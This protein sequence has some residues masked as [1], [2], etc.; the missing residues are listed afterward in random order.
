MI[1]LQSKAARL[2]VDTGSASVTSMPRNVR[3]LSE[4]PGKRSLG[5]AAGTRAPGALSIRPFEGSRWRLRRLR[6]AMGFE[7]TFAA[8]DEPLRHLEKASY[9]ESHRS[10]RARG[11]LLGR[12]SRVR[13]LSEVAFR[14][15]GTRPMGVPAR[16]QRCREATRSMWCCSEEVLL[17]A[18]H[19]LD[20]ASYPA[21]KYSAWLHD[22]GHAY[23]PMAILDLHGSAHM[24]L[25]PDQSLPLNFC[26]QRGIEIMDELVLLRLLRDRK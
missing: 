12:Y 15:R 1:R 18:R 5:C 3:F 2:V 21:R 20:F 16:C 6:Q 24:D 7:S 10:K 13:T 4:A 8:G 17:I 25:H 26:R 19:T 23:S 22:S 14:G 9:G 11:G